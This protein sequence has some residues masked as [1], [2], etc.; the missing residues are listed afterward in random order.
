[1]SLP[2]SSDSEP[3]DLQAGGVTCS[4]C[5]AVDGQPDH[6]PDLEA[7]IFATVTGGQ[8]M[9]WGLAVN[10]TPPVLF[11]TP[12]WM[13]HGWLAASAI[14]VAFALGLPLLKTL[15][16]NL[17]A[18]RISVEG[19]FVVTALGGFIASLVATFTGEGDVY[20]EV[21]AIVLAIYTFGKRVGRRTREKIVAE[22]EQAEQAFHFCSLID[23]SGETQRVP[24]DEVLPGSRVE[25]SAGEQLT[26]DG[27]VESGNGWL[28]TAM[29]TGE[30][31]P[32]Y[33]EKGATVKA[34]AF[35][36]NGGLVVS[37][38]RSGGSRELDEIFRSLREAFT[39]ASQIERWTDRLT[40]QFLPFVLSASLLTGIVWTFLL[41]WAVGLF[42]AMAVLLVACPCALG[43]ATPIAVWRGLVRLAGKGIV[44]RD[45][46]LLD[47]LGTTREIFWDKTGTLTEARLE[48][49]EARFAVEEPWS[50]NELKSLAATVESA[51]D[52]PIAECLQAAGI[53]NED[54]KVQQP[55]WVAGKGVSAQ[56]K[57]LTQGSLHVQMGALSSLMKAGAQVSETLAIGSLP[58]GKRIGLAV[59]GTV[60]ALFIIREVLR[61]D[62]VEVLATLEAEGIRST[63]LTGDPEPVGGQGIGVAKIHSGLSAMTTAEFVERSSN[64]GLNPVLVGDGFN[65]APGMHAAAGSIAMASGTQLTQVVGAG[66]LVTEKLQSIVEGIRI[67]REVLRRIH[68]NLYFSA[69]YNAIG[70]GLAALGWLHPVV[71]AVLMLGSSLWVSWRAVR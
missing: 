52:H 46:R 24:V 7:L 4:A 70:I 67:S 29:T 16:A 17:K 69:G 34:G 27:V 43:L 25:V 13:L 8:S 9:V 5:C 68:G 44:S 42:N 36:R 58:E 28:D 49:V 53:A 31:E 61:P 23:E 26:V 55:R 14:I 50:E 48:I 22:V 54:W 63:I 6:E 20:Y 40:Q 62:A 19:L 32:F 60:R 33:V 65:D 57:H 2:A 56:V 11:S 12:Y 10:L 66:V 21:V 59:D 18:R 45:V 3:Q 35:L 1:M 47:A 30:P 41:G 37:V 64:E 71:A 15:F 38:E 51:F 39:H